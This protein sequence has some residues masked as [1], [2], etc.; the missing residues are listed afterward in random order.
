M[1][2]GELKKILYVEDD[3]DI[4]RIAQLALEKVGGFDVKIC[5][6]GRE[7]LAEVTDFCPDLMLLDIMLPEMDGLTILEALQKNQETTHI[8]VVFITARVPADEVIEYQK[9]GALDVISKPFDPM[10][11]ASLLKEIWHNRQA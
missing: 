9:R 6:T 7:A 4:Q 3:R 1:I 2:K 11:L 5:S 10:K 8:P